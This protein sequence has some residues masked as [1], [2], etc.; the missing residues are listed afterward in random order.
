MIRD[1]YHEVIISVMISYVFVYC[2][3]LV[4]WDGVVVELT[5]SDVGT[6]AVSGRSRTGLLK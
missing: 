6:I 3:Q 5:I 2:L 1:G 4:Q